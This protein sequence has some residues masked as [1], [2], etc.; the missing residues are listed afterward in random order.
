MNFGSRPV[1]SS[2]MK[3][4]RYLRVAP[5]ADD[6]DVALLQVAQVGNV[7]LSS[8]F[9]LVFRRTAQVVVAE[10]PVHV[11]GITRAVETLRPVGPVAVGR[12]QERLRILDHP[13]C[14]LPCRNLHR[15]VVGLGILRALR[16]RRNGGKRPGKHDGGE[17]NY[18]SEVLHP[19]KDRKKRLFLQAISRYRTR[20][21]A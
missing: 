21:R 1:L 15:S 6:Q 7:H 13:V 18:L 11:A 20:S 8:V 16:L 5:A 2:S 19:C 14:E 9:R 17:K 3:M 10:M 4:A 12:P